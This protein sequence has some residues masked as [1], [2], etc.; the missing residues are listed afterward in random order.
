MADETTRLAGSPLTL[1]NRYRLLDRLGEGGMGAVYRALD[2]LTGETVALKHVTLA[3]GQLQ[4]ALQ[5]EDPMLALAQEFQVLSSLRHPH[6]IAVRDYGFDLERRPFFTMDLLEQPRTIVQVAQ[7]QPLE[8]KINLLQQMLWALVYLHRRGIVHRDLKPGNVLVADGTVKVTDFGLSV[9]VERADANRAGSLGYMA[10]EVLLDE[11][12]TP[13][14]DLYAVGVI[15]YEMFAGRHPFDT[16]DLST[17][18]D[19][20]L[21]TPPAQVLTR[22]DSPVT[23]ILE[24][25]LAK[26]P[27]ER[28]ADATAVIRA[29]GAATGQPLALETQETRESFLQA[30]KFVGREV[31]LNQLSAALAEAQAGRGSAWLIG[32][33]SGVGK[34]RLADELRTRALIAGV[35]VLRGQAVEGGGLPYQLWR[36]PIRRLILSTGLSDLESS[37]LKEI[38]PDIGRLL[39]RAVPDAPA[40]SGAAE[41]SRLELTLVDLF[42]RQTFSTL[43]LLE[44]LQWA[45]ESLEPLK[46]LLRSAAHLSVLIVGSYRNDERPSLPEELPETQILTL[47]RLSESA[48]A[49]LSA[50]ML[51]QAGQQ[52]QMAELLV[53][54]TEG[55][56]FFLVE[57]VRALAEEAGGLE[58]IAT[59]SL[60]RRVMAG[61]VQAV[62]RRRLGR[63]P[64]WARPALKLAAVAGRRID[65]KVLSAASGDTDWEA[66]LTACVNAAV[67]EVRDEQLRFSHDKLRE[68]LLA[69][70]ND[71]ERPTLHYQIAAALEAAYP[72][73]DAYA[74]PLADHW[75]A[76]GQSARALPY[77]VQAARR[78]TDITAH[79]DRAEQWIAR[80]LAYSDSVHRAELFLLWGRVAEHR[81]DFVTAAARYQSCLATPGIELAQRASALNGLCSALWRQGDFAGA[82]EQALLALEA[83]RAAGDRRTV[84][85]ALT[86]LGIVCE[87]MADYAN[88]RKSYEESLQ[89]CH[90]L[91]DRFA[92]I[93]VLNNLGALHWNLGDYAASKKYCMESLDIAREFGER[94]GILTALSNVGLACASQG[95]YAAAQTYYEE[96]LAIVREVGD[97]QNTALTLV[98][99]GD[100]MVGLGKAA[101]AQAFY[102]EGLSIAREIGARQDMVWALNG[103]GVSMGAQGKYAAAREFYEESLCISRDMNDRPVIATI[104]A[105]Y[106]IT[107]LRLNEYV[108]ARETVAEA[109][110]IARDVGV[111]PLLVQALAA[112]SY[113]AHAN[114]KAEVAA[115]WLGLIAARGAL[116]PTFTPFV[117]QLSTE[118]EAALG[119]EHYVAAQER[120]RNLELNA[121]VEELLQDGA[122]FDLLGPSRDP[123]HCG[124]ITAA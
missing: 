83:G 19:Q 31:E 55:N 35:L 53:R 29:L 9:T 39:G 97:R 87:M 58:G 8:G 75:D 109:L 73:D 38:V 11:L 36:E 25:L 101:S 15:A 24:R 77:I 68:T 40:L 123:G 114:G 13:S 86:N 118:L 30:A 119:T 45:I 80:G 32:G 43:L 92:S 42:K 16:Q 65:L 90:E 98:N 120:G 113:W 6:I 34:S 41:R 18:V 59:M 103:L 112:A 105:S 110:H 33:E 63:A 74:E 66:W 44:D 17:L 22:I 82:K 2:R 28:Y 14:A 27:A 26:T 67:L 10:P 96:N 4:F 89:I 94:N 54:E 76:A 108:K 62:I 37:V 52:P 93:P 115:A 20:I 104:Q 107:L 100:L 61:G 79:Y 78:L 69:D 56:T 124:I 106:V 5:G 88:A 72:G 12:V 50:A 70:L 85:R 91:G 99:L 49:E 111:K 7:S 64:L 21:E 57:V 122:P 117:S 46:A 1:G 47:E 3:P 81:G 121:V 23:A 51:G 95:D 84:T 102:Q 48:V 116:P 60:P 71:V